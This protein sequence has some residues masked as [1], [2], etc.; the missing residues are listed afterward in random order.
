M[1]LKRM[2]L[3]A[4]ILSGMAALMYEV[5]WTRPLSMVFGSTTYALSTILAA[6]MAG[7]GLGGYLGGR[8]ADRL[9][10]PAAVYAL[11]ELG[12]GIYA[13][14]LI[15]LFNHLPS[16]YVSLYSALHLQF[17][18]FTFVQFIVIF[19][20]L[21]IPTCLMGATFPVVVKFYTEEKVGT[22]IG[23]LYAGNTLGAM[24]GSFAAGFALIPVLGIKWSI[25]LVGLINL[26]VG[27]SILFLSSPQLTKKV[28]PVGFVLFLIFAGSASYD[29][30]KFTIGSFYYGSTALAENLEVLFYREGLY[31]TVTVVRYGGE[32]S[33]MINGKGQGGTGFADVRTNFFLAYLP[34]LLHPDPKTSLNIGLGTGTTSGILSQY[35]HTTTVEIDPA[36]VEA[37]KSF[38]DVNKDVLNQENHR[39]VL[40]DA[41]NYLLL[42]N[43]KYDLIT[44]EPADPW[45]QR[46]TMLYSK[47][48]FEIIKNHLNE[49]G[50]FTQWVPIYE[51]SAD[52]FRT[53]YHTFHAVFPHVVAFG[54]A[55]E[56][57]TILV[58]ENENYWFFGNITPVETENYIGIK[59]E[60]NIEIVYV[61]AGG[62]EENSRMK[63]GEIFVV[64]KEGTLRITTYRVSE[65]FLIGSLNEIK[66]N[67]SEIENKIKERRK[68]ENHETHN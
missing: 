30:E 1:N 57:E 11:L 29:I 9:K 5:I 64:E 22:G 42:T 23:T 40:A 12:I 44:S 45:Q 54:N 43:E 51:F 56:V 8:Y 32:K 10:N 16:L 19:F 60:E 62:K 35:T 13:V 52:D 55:G 53:L 17:G 48:F 24:I 37:S 7:L 61:D 58:R 46:S 49:N 38:K 20:V 4:F 41:R 18:L 3:I 65:I 15:T 27:S 28:V 36:I 26:A 25:V 59:G 66:I 68:R 31:G 50:L 67:W 33:L 39:L 63:T 6:F 14:L 47:E 21:L 34:L 2:I